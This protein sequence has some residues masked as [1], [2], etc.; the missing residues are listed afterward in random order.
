MITVIDEY[1]RKCLAIRAA[2]RFRSDQ[3][4]ELLTELFTMNGPSQHIRSDNGPEFTA[5]V[6]RGWLPK[7][8]VQTLFIEPGSPWENG[9]NESFNGKLKEV[10][11]LTERWRR[12]YNTIRPHSSLGY[13]PPAPEVIKTRSQPGLKPR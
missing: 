11:I 7:V 6:V 5:K 12:E 10:Q 3:V 2:R 1:S 13:R 9:Y 8:G 4:L